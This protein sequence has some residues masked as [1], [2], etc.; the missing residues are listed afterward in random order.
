MIFI[1][2][3]ISF[4]SVDRFILAFNEYKYN[5]FFKFGQHSAY[6]LKYLF[7]NWKKYGNLAVANFNPQINLES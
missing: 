1:L 4:K 5:V 7:Q 2:R 3:N 6:F